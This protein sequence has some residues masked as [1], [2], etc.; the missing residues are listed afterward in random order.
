MNRAV[1]FRILARDNFTCQ[2]CGR[3]AP[4]VVLEIDHIRPSAHGGPDR[5][6]NL[7]TACY[8]C[9]HGKRDHLLSAEQ[10]DFFTKTVTPSLVRKRV[11][12]RAS[13]RPRPAKRNDEMVRLTVL[14]GGAY[15]R[16]IWRESYPVAEKFVYVGPDQFLS[17]F[18]CS[19]CGMINSYEGDSC[20]CARRAKEEEERVWCYEC[21]DVLSEVGELYCEDCYWGRRDEDEED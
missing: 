1:R 3:R 12:H 7:I 2:Y 10:A 18:V 15:E 11:A 21:E 16:T 9:N 8:D 14:N 6:M 17:T 20:G 19:H 13:R 4:D 5:I